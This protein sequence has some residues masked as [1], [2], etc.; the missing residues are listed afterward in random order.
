[1]RGSAMLLL[2]GLSACASTGT[3]PRLGQG[4]WRAV[5][6]NGHPVD[7][8]RAPTLRLAEGQ[9]SGSGGCN[10]FSGPYRT[11]SQER[12]R[13]GP[14]AVTR[15]ACEPPLMEQEGR[16]LSILSAASGYSLYGDGSVSIISADGRA[17]RFRR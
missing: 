6:V 11:L 3:P 12:I 2:L 14:L 9:A 1:M 15:M 10:T 8:A 4:E 5:D 16:F 7:P 13:F 17:V